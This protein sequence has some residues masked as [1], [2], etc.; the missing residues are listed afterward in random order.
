[1]HTMKVFFSM[2]SLAVGSLAQSFSSDASCPSSMMVL[3]AAAPMPPSYLQTLLPDPANILKDPAEYASSLCKVAA[4]L[5]ASQLSAFGSWGQSLL[6]FAATELSS[7]DGLITKCYHAT[8]A[9][10]ASATSYIHSIVSQT[11]PLCQ[12]TSAPGGENGP[13]NGTATITPAPTP[14]GTSSSAPGNSSTTM[15]IVTGVAAKPTSIFASAAGLVGFI[16]AMA[17]L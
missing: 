13:S 3:A 1:M 5:P 14:T 12:E 9:E 2:G 6:S 7:Y 17:L 16:A 4:E 11:A 10:A 15:M 8:G